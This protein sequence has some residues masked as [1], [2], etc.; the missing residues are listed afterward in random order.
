MCISKSKLRP[1]E[2]GDSAKSKNDQSLGQERSEISQQVAV[3]SSAH[4]LQCVRETE[5]DLYFMS[6]FCTQARA[7]VSRR[8]CPSEQELG[9]LQKTLSVYT[10]T[11]YTNVGHV[12]EVRGQLAVVDPV[13][14]LWAWR[15][16]SLPAEPSYQLMFLCRAS[17]SQS[18]CLSFP[19]LDDR[20]APTHPI[21]TDKETEAQRAGTQT[22]K[23][24]RF[25]LCL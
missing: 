9:P 15:Q 11:F 14:G 12:C 16:A 3:F 23:L 13:D 20:R 2:S 8:Q 7:T 21:S 22:R 1:Q 6:G 19:S 17:N 25:P 4:S 5:T 18:L 24:T 10:F